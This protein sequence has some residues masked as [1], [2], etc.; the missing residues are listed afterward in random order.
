MAKLG[1]ALM[2]LFL[3]KQAR[4]A[5]ENKA[6]FRAPP[7]Q[8]PLTQAQAQ[9]QAQDIAEPHPSREELNARLDT[10]AEVRAN[11]AASP[12][13]Q[14]LIEDAL[15]VRANKAKIL[16]DLPQ[17]QRLKLQAMARMTFLKVKDGGNGG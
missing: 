14:R 5:L 12:N 8:P 13:R 15:R 7:P 17:E 16:E 1:K 6:P 4:E 11:R 9:A 3:D 10:A 2:S